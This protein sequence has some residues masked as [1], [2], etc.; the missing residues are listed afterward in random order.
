MTASRSDDP[1]RR[2]FLGAA[3]A[4]AVGAGVAATGNAAAQE[5]G[6]DF[7]GWFD[8]VDNFDGVVDARGQG[9]VTVEV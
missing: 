9:E 5:S 3:A 8:D 4:G 7:G 6:V 1:T 2:A